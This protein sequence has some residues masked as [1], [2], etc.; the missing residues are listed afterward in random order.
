MPTA[1]HHR[2]TSNGCNA[3]DKRAGLCNASSPYVLYPTVTKW[4]G[5]VWWA[6]EAGADVGGGKWDSNR[7]IFCAT[8][9]ERFC[10]RTG[11]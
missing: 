3:S 10:P 5:L 9:A 11:L 1:G 2:R 7:L 4:R 8:A 6:L